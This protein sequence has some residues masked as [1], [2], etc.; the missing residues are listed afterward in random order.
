MLCDYDT[1]SLPLAL[2]C[3]LRVCDPYLPKD[4]RL[5][6]KLDSFGG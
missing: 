2:G 3:C 5:L 6:Y 4:L 1:Y